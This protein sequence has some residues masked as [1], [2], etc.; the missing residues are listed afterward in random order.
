[1]RKLTSFIALLLAVKF[2]MAQGVAIN[3]N[4]AAPNSSAMLDV[5]STTKGMLIPRMTT[6]QRAAIASPAK[7]LM[8]FDTGVN[9]FWFYNGSA[10]INLSSGAAT[11]WSV[12]GNSGTNSASNYLGTSDTASLKIKTNNQP[13]VTITGDGSV[14]INTTSPVAQLDV[15]SLKNSSNTVNGFTAV[16]TNSG[17]GGAYAGGFTAN[18]SNSGNVAAVSAYAQNGSYTYGFVGTAS[19]TGS[20]HGYGVYGVATGS[21]PY[22]WGGYFKGDWIGVEGFGGTGVKGTGADGGVFTGTSTGVTASGKTGGEFTATHTGIKATVNTATNT[23]GFPQYGIECQVI[24]TANTDQV[25]GIDCFVDGKNAKSNVIGIWSEPHGAVSNS[26]ISFYGVGNTLITGNYY[27]TSDAKLK[28]NIKPVQNMMDKIMQLKPSSY[29]YKTEEYKMNLPKGNQFGLIAQDVQKVF[30][31]LVADQVKPARFDKKTKEKLSDE[32][33][34]LSVNYTGLIPIIISGMQDLKKENATLKSE[35]EQLK[36][37]I[38]QI[39]ATLARIS[40]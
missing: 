32:V 28:Q 17:T 29:Q 20:Q 36:N 24:N 14:G 27:S 22:S 35:N 25:E 39:K 15:R 23:G 38:A 21:Y 37:D 11:G 19:T 1:M 12:T 31:E 2:S 13:R 9:S 3:N 7:G 34:F 33:K 26:V 6:A 30:P 18:G 4:N 40:K 8:V 16:A 10:W 5:Q